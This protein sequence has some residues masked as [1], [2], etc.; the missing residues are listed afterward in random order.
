[1]PPLNRNIAFPD[2]N[3]NIRKVPV[4]DDAIA[5]GV[6][7]CKQLVMRWIVYVIKNYIR[8]EY[9]FIAALKISVVIT[10]TKSY[11]SDTPK[12]GSII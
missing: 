7:A 12:Y 4:K 10:I 2:V 11:I 9:L 1:M 8:H 6:C 5:F 3:S